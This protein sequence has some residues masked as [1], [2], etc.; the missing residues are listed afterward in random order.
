MRRRDQFGHE[1]AGRGHVA[2]RCGLFFLHS[3]TPD[4]RAIAEV[5]ARYYR[6]RGHEPVE[7]V[8]IADL[9]DDD[10]KR[11]CTRG[12]RNL[13][14][15]VCRV[16]QER[17]AAAC[18]VNATGG[19]KAQIA[20]AVL[21]GQSL[22]VPV[23]Y[24]HERFSVIVAFPP[25]PVALDFDLWQCAS[26][27]L[28]RLAAQDVLPAEEYAEEWE[29]KFETLVEREEID[30]RPYL[31]LSPT[32]QIFHDT[33]RQRFRVASAA[34]LPPAASAAQKKAPR[35]E[36]SGWPG[37]HP[38]VEAFLR[39]VTAEVPAVRHCYTFYYNPDLTAETRFR[40]GGRGVEGVFSRGGYCVKFGV[41]STARNRA[42]ESA[43]VAA[44][45]E[46]LA[47]HEG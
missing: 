17:S 13:A 9:Q 25:M 47:S 3:A 10:P 32:G 37:A 1:P 18:A 36:Q 24:K 28:Y 30:G 20:I 41:E 26:G 45:N 15:I 22:G 21:L 7:A 11:F 19:Y 38:E 46:W 8:E 16:V 35:L 43:V 5:L 2:D 27:L 33:F 14:R 23:F 39:R 6:A 31:T 4:G 29:E 42:E 34:V 40:L 44:L 12:L